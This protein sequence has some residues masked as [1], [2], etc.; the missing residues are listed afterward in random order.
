M[1]DNVRHTRVLESFEDFISKEIVYCGIMASILWFEQDSG[2]HEA[3]LSTLHAALTHRLTELR[4]Y[5]VA[6]GYRERV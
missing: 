6:Q 3:I 2:E 4:E 5:Y 1:V